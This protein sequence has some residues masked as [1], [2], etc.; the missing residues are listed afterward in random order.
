MRSDNLHHTKGNVSEEGNVYIQ[1]RGL[2]L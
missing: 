1:L 2:E